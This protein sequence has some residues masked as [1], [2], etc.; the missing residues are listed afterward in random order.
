MSENSDL[1]GIAIDAAKIGGETLLAHFLRSNSA[2]K[3]QSYNLV[4]A[5][6]LQ[7]EKNIVEFIRQRFPTHH[8]LGEE[9]HGSSG[10]GRSL[11]NDL[12]DCSCLW[13]IDPLDGTNNFVHGIPHFAV[14]IAYFENGRPRVGVVFNPASGELYHA[15]SGTP[16][17][18]NNQVICVNSAEALNQCLVGVGFYYDRD[19]TLKPT[20]NAIEEMFGAGIHGIRRMGTAS[21]DLCYVASGRFG[22]YFEYGLAPWDFAAGWLIVEQAGGTV[23]QCQAKPLTL[24]YSS[25]VASN[26]K[27]HRQATTITARHSPTGMLSEN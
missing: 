22:A 20:L 25:V 5:A 11:I 7:S 13:V 27:V 3:Q 12:K 15:T 21:L 4:T 2:Q 26:S 24:G 14:S 9:M 19:A 8:V 23:T 6:D 16:S 17:M 1:L 18:H 10:D